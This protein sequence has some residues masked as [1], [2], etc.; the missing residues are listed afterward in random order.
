M[1]HDVTLSNKSWKEEGYGGALVMK[2]SVL[3]NNCV[4]Y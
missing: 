2:M 3:L 1:L 4:I